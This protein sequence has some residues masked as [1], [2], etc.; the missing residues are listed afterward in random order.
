MC[1]YNTTKSRVL[2]SPVRYID[3]EEYEKHGMII[4]EDNSE[5][6]KVVVGEEIGDSGR[7]AVGVGPL[8]TPINLTSPI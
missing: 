8:S 3:E 4:R 1:P 6:V 2:Y 7:Q 5:C